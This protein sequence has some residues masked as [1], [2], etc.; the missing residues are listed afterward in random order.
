MKKPELNSSKNGVTA[1]GNK[2]TAQAGADIMSIGGNAV[3]AAVGAAFV[4]FVSEGSLVNFCGG[5]IAQVVDPNSSQTITYDFFANM[6][7]LD[8]KPTNQP[9][10]FRKITVDFGATTQDF[11]VG[12]GSVAVPGNLFGLCAMH[13]D[14]GRLQLAEVLR[15]AIDLAR[16]GAPLDPFQALCSDLLKPILTGTRSVQKIFEP[17]GSFVKEGD[18]VKIP[19]LAETFEEIAQ[20]GERPLRFGRLAEALVTDQE[21]RGGLVTRQDLASYNVIRSQPIRI[22]YRGHEV[23]LPRPASTGGVLTAFALKLLSRFDI[24]KFSRGSADHLQVLIEAMSASTR[25]RPHWEEGRQRLKTND[26]IDRFLADEFVADYATEAMTAIIRGRPSRIHNEQL[27][28]NDTTHISVVDSN[29]MA[30]SITTSSG[31]SA[32]YVIPGTGLIP[33]NMLGEEDLFPDGFH[34]YPAGQRIYTM[35]TPT[36]VLK[37][38]KARLVTGS[39]GSIRIRSAILQIISNVLDFGHQL[40][41]ATTQ[42]RVHLENKVLQCEA[43]T[44]SSAMDELESLGYEINRWSKRSMYFGGAHSIMIDRDGN[45]YAFGDPRRSGTAAVSTQ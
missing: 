18:L 40:D 37:D 27:S 24:P 9:L 38:G 28:H 3:D 39:G 31:E 14:F 1:A 11:F 13:R 21:Q 22:P 17:E 19:D 15:P 45:N 44:E 12:R 43:G 25:A 36:I 41:E 6:P 5:G 26:A 16:K 32:G 42:A 2:H 34:N 8:Q 33:N 30:V 20:E 23:L 7:G 35:M 29:G 10:D 4:S